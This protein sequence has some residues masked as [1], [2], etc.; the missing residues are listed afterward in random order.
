MKLAF[1]FLLALAITGFIA[2]GTDAPSDQGQDTTNTDSTTANTSADEYTD[3][4][5]AVRSSHDCSVEGQVLEGNQLWLREKEILVAITADSATYDENYGDSHRIFKVYNTLT[6][7]ETDRQVLPINESPDFPYY[8]AEI[9]YNNASQLVAIKGF[10]SVY[11]YDVE[12]QK[13]LPELKPEFKAERYS[14]DASSGMIARVEVWE[15]YLVGYAAEFGSFVFDLS[16]TQAPKAVLPFAE[17][18]IPEE[19]FATLFLLESGDK[20]VQAIMP[21]YD[22]NEDEFSANP[23]FAKPQKVNT[24]VPANARNNRYLV[25]REENESRTPIALDLQ[26]HEQVTL[27]ANIASQKTQDILKWMRSQ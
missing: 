15:K 21:S 6:C 14:S 3:A 27:P 9:N 8:I 10:K 25:L 18:E 4:S 5:P 13:L 19:G 7:E 22:I 11:C 20:G 17:Y 23:L 1:Q 12:G 24:N 26:K 16:N 2:C